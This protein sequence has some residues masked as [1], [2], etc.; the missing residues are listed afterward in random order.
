[1]L[2]PF[3]AAPGP[4]A[5]APWRVAGLPGGK[6]PLARITLAEVDGTRVAKL[7]TAGAYGTLVHDIT[8][9]VPSPGA[10]LAWRW[11]LDQPLAHADLRT[12]EGDDAALKVCVMFDL[13]L[14]ALP[15]GER[16][17]LRMAR[18]ISAEPLPAATLCYVWDPALPAGTTL[19]NAYSARVRWRVLDGPASP[20]RQWR[21]HRQNLSADFLQ[22]FGH[23]ST[24]V[25]P[26]LAVVIGADSD[27][28][29]GTS[30]AYVGDLRLEP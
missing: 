5:P 6:V 24:T 3:S 28:T 10:T 21:S 22:A 4:A 20:L 11:R 26:I 1:M 8:P 7:A 23:E 2:A 30:L 13:P 29:A 9:W 16:T 27:N 17:L 25:P 19:P 15:F 14:S 12:R 18:A